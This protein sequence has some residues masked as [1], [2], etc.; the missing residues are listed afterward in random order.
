MWK[1]PYIGSIVHW[2]LKFILCL[3][4]FL[5][6]YYKYKIFRFSIPPLIKTTHLLDIWEISSPPIIK[7]PRLFGT[8]ECYK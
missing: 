2:C 6:I 4:S 1:N 3:Y 7:T 5:N 8:L